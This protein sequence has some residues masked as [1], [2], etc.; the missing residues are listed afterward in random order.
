MARWRSGYARDCKSLNAGSIP[1]RAFFIGFDF[2]ICGYSALVICFIFLLF[3]VLL[4]CFGS[5]AQL[6]RVPP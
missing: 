3:Y 6:V 4:C 1:A 2:I 5:L